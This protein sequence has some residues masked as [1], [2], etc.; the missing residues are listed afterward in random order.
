M[1]TR[2]KLI[3]GLSLTPLALAARNAPA[4]EQAKAKPQFLFVQSAEGV[5]YADG[6]LT[7]K[8]VNPITVLFSDR[9]ERLAGHMATEELVPFWG[10]GADSFK[11]NP[12]NADL[13]MLDGS[14]AENVVVTLQD[15]KLEGRDLSYRVDLLEGQPPAS[16][17]AASLF[18][19]I[20]GLPLTPVSFAGARRRMW[21]RRALY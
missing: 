18:I 12:P 19:D 8:E 21:R 7:L 17:G 13:A 9:P 14:K 11:A 16:G 5:Q 20:I 2:R 3:L 1:T 10:E 6:V 15:P 4:A